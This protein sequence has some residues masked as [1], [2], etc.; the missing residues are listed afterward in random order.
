MDDP[1]AILV[2]CIKAVCGDHVFG[3]VV[4]DLHE[5]ADF[6]IGVLRQLDTDL[7]IDLLI[8]P[9]ADEVDLFGG[10]LPNVDL[11][12]PALQFQKHDVLQGPVQHLSVI[13]QEA[14]FQ[15][16]VGQ[17]ILL[18][19]GQDSLPLDVIAVAGVDD[20]RLLQPAQVV[21]DGLYR[22]RAVLIAQ[23]LGDRAG[24][25]GLAHVLHQILHYPVK[26]ILLVDPVP[27][28]NT[29]RLDNHAR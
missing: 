27:F 11:I 2:V 20:E 12:V 17:I 3:V 8:T 1:N 4:L 10:M 6:P 24:R 15:C 14:V 9:D 16:D 13:A 7:D 22:D 29:I 5:I 25:E 18:L 23:E 28:D 19:G 26:E 21:I